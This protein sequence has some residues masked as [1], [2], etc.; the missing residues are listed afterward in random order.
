[1]SKRTLQRRVETE[2]TSFQQILKETREALAHH[3][4][5]NTTLPAS[6]ISS[7]LGDDEPNFFYRAFRSWTGETPDTIRHAA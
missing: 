6:E 1:M 4:L 7:F 2:G 3:Y 5:E